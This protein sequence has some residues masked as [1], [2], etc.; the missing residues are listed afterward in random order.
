MKNPFVWGTVLISM[1]TLVVGCSEPTSTNDLTTDATEAGDALSEEVVTE[2]SVEE[3]APGTSADSDSEAAEAD[4]TKLA[5][6]MPAPPISAAS[7]V[8]GTAVDQFENGHVYVVEFWATWCGPC[9]RSMPHM[10]SLQTEY[11]EDVSF[12]GIS[13]EDEA[14]VKAFLGKEQSEGKTWDEVITY[15]MALDDGR[16]SINNSYMRAA[17]QQGIPTAFIVGRDGK[18]EWIGHPI[19]MDEPLKQIVDGSYD[20]E[21]AIKAYE[22][23]QLAAAIQQEVRKHFI[24]GDFDSAIAAIDKA[25][26]SMPGTPNLLGMKAQAL[27]SSGRSA[28]AMVVYESLIDGNWDNPQLL[29]A[30]AWQLTTGVD[31]ADLAIAM[32]AAQRASELT[33][34]SDGAILDTVARVYYEQANYPE[35]VEWQKKA[36]AATPDNEDLKKTLTEYEQKIPGKTAASEESTTDE[37]AEEGTAKPADTEDAAT[38]PTAPQNATPP[39]E[40]SSDSAPP[41]DESAEEKPSAE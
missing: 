27:V 20:R 18:V 21:A 23:E 32:K 16:Q 33:E 29:N 28:D 4:A 10:A 2:D 12:V 22:A 37:P 26:E 35:A 1:F 36:V 11:A 38:E 15:T 19:T 30:V 6:G 14:T 9:I 39:A 41:A 40:E 17:N 5:I 24:S 3:M 7:V 34:Q 8:K 31:D 13:N 25:L